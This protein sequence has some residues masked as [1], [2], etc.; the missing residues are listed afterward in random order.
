MNIL[1]TGGTGFIGQLFIKTFTDYQYTVLTRNITKAEKI[2]S[3]DT[4]VGFITDLN[5]LKNLDDFDAVINL[6]GEPIADKRWTDQQKLRIQSSRWKITEQL[7][8]LF[9]SSSS[10][11]T[12]FISGSAIGFYGNHNA[13]E[14]TELSQTEH[15]DFSSK[16]CQTWEE[17][18]STVSSN[19]RVVLLRT[20]IVL[21]PKFGA[22][23][24]MLMPFKLGLGGRLGD[25][26]QYFSWIHWQDMVSAIHFLLIDETLSGVFNMTA[27]NPVTNVQFSKS[28]GKALAR[29][30]FMPMPEWVLKLLMGESSELLLISQRVQPQSLLEAGYQF[31]YTELDATLAHLIN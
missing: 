4:T 26:S 8:A 7:V 31:R 15:P 3:A 23:S 9:E 30:A 22:L 17:K 18:A 20:G 28:L 13:L 16:L 25:G 11:P 21:H 24:K 10:P 1:I 5:Q 19:T 6:A 29:P 14:I 27:P 2:F 12:T